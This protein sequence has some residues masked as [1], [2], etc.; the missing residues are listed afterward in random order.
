MGVII[1]PAHCQCTLYKGQCAIGD[2]L[3]RKL[4]SIGQIT[5]DIGFD[6]LPRHVQQ[7][8]LLEYCKSLARYLEHIHEMGHAEAVGCGCTR[9]TPGCL[10][11]ITLFSK[12]Q[13]MRHLKLEILDDL[14]TEIGK[15]ICQAEC[16]WQEEYQ[17][18]VRAHGGRG[19]A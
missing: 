5:S 14:E 19:D 15:A 2:E 1:E 12:Y 13:H 4:N 9:K 8:I 18:H 3:F 11:G 10:G 7:A 6:E 16:Y 17:K